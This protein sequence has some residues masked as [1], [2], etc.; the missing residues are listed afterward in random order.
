MEP[1]VV[2]R[3]LSPRVREIVPVPRVGWLKN[4][5]LHQ[6]GIA[7]TRHIVRFAI[8][9]KYH[10]PIGEYPVGYHPIVIG[11]S[12]R[13]GILAGPRD[14]AILAV[15]V[16]QRCSRRTIRGS[17]TVRVRSNHPTEPSV[18][19]NTQVEVFIA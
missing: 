12:L 18:E 1:I 9:T 15:S 10:Y 14:T 2:Q 19:P 3:T 6:V 17:V 5:L 7:F 13:V 16:T 4:A 11:D 8:H